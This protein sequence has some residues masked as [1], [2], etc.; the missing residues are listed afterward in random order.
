MARP[1]PERNRRI[2]G[3]V[4]YVLFMLGGGGALIFLFAMRRATPTV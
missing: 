3:T 1:D 2:I 4:L